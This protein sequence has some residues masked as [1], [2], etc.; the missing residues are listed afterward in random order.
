MLRRKNY[1]DKK[2]VSYDK[3]YSFPFFCFIFVGLLN[4]THSYN[5]MILGNTMLNPSKDCHIRL[6]LIHNIDN[7]KNLNDNPL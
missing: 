2:Y 3:T 1:Q 6:R 4:K 7:Y 5:T